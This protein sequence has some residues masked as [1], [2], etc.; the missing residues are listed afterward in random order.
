MILPLINLNGSD[1]MDLALQ[2]NKA[3]NLLDE[4]IRAMGSI[5]HG[6]DYPTGEYEAAR[7]EMNERIAK[8]LAVREEI[9]T[10]TLHCM[11]SN[12]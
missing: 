10:I 6:R 3:T 9:Q 11:D 8:V 4:A 12:R 7:E 1:A 2:Y 5:I